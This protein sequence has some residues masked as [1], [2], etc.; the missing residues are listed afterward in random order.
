MNHEIAFPYPYLIDTLDQ[1]YGL[2]SRSSRKTI[3]KENSKRR[4]SSRKNSKKK[5]SILI[6]TFWSFPHVGGLSNY[7]STLSKGLKSQGHK[8]DIISPNQFSMS[9][10]KQ[11]REVATPNL[12]HFFTKRYGSYNDRILN[13]Q[14]LIYVYEKM[15]ETINLEK[16]D[17]L[18]AQ[19]LFTANIL[20]RFNEFYNKPLFYTPHGMFTSNRLKFNIIKKSSVEE[21]YFTELESKAIEYAS[22]IIVLS[23][24]FREPLIKL[25]AKNRN[26]TTVITGIDYPVN[27]REGKEKDSQKLVIT[28]VARLGP[29]KGHNYLFDALARLKKYT[30][31]VEVLIVGDGQMREKLEKQKKA[32]GL[33]MVN[34][35]GSRDDVPSLLNKTD[36]FVL[37]TIN[38]S[39]PIS[40]IEAMHSGTAVIS[41]NCGGIPE[42]IKHNK[43]G[44]IVE[45]GD[46][47]QL[48][49]ALKFLITNKEVRNKMSTTAKNHAKNHLTVD[50]MV[51]KIK[52]LYTDFWEMN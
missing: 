39:L 12:K 31:N 22:H 34:F 27:Q 47:E 44:I 32:L 43:T 16:Y 51:G 33:S 2:K 36:I 17:I 20:G 10:V 11:F 7:I 19:D 49:H 25:G 42:L 28:C 52:H 26:I 24:S 46:P 3:S 29:R 45:P 5:F 48:A 30:S 37:P 6:A 38:D 14:R 40:I 23:D 50:S 21:A 15:L 18:H 1:Y 9:K 8:V 4:S 35:L 13:H 41:T